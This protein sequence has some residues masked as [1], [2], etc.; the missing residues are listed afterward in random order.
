MDDG[1]DRQ[2]VLEDISGQRT[3]PNIFIGGE[4]FGGNSDVKAAIKDG[5]LKELLDKHN[6][7]HKF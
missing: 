5:S 2:N 3:V 6:I 7:K 4:H 1:A